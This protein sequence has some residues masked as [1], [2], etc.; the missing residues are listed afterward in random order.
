M[1]DH[2]PWVPVGRASSVAA[3]GL[4]VSLLAVQV[5]VILASSLLGGAL[6]GFLRQPKVVGQILAGIALGPSVFGVLD[7][8]VHAFLF[9]G[10]SFVHL[11]ALSQAGIVIFMFLVGVELNLGELRTRKRSVWLISQGGICIPFALGL[12]LTPLLKPFVD[13][14]KPNP[15]GFSLFLGSA[16]SI[17]AMPVLVRILSERGLARTATGQISIAAAGLNDAIG[18]LVLGAVLAFSAGQGTVM[19]LAARCGLLLV[20]LVC[21]LLVRSI[22]NSRLERMITLTG[23][24]SDESVAMVLIGAIASAAATEYLGIHAL[25]G[26]LLAGML[27]PKRNEIV[28]EISSRIEPFAKILLL[29][30][31]FAVS[32]IRTDLRSLSLDLWLHVFLVVAFASIGKI[33][34]AGL[35]AYLSGLR[36]RESVAIGIL[37]NTRGLMELVALNLGL[38]AGVITKQLFTVFVLMA[39]MTTSMTAPLLSLAGIP[40]RNT[41]SDLSE[42][43][44]QEDRL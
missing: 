10:S 19:D 35:G 6:A 16:L 23:K 43:C 30:L 21:A 12:A 20:Y 11:Q 42:N 39:V 1:S 38:E 17:T 36:F 14:L 27:L 7:E 13:D 24:L 40:I 26:A 31:F 2:V 29:P 9:P 5:A 22:L 28:Y 3:E 25:F 15:L 34:G 41:D 8:R 4:N 33:F 44:P 32:G 18:W 37:M